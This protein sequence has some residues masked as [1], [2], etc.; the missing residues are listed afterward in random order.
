MRHEV[1]ESLPALEIS[2]LREP[3]CAAFR[4]QCEGSNF[5][6]EQIAFRLTLASGAAF[7]AEAGLLRPSVGLASFGLFGLACV[8]VMIVLRCQT[9]NLLR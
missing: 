6:S 9:I 1:Y 8:F 3:R 2:W 7:A 4:E 5:I